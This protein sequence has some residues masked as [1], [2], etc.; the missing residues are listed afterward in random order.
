M[1]LIDSANVSITAELLNDMR[2]DLEDE[3]CGAEGGGGGEHVDSSCFP[4]CVFILM[5]INFFFVVFSCGV[6][7]ILNTE[8][9]T[10]SRGLKLEALFES[11]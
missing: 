9:L 4:L 1:S 3:V 2:G 8:I 11:H 7:E 10:L 6:D 5:E